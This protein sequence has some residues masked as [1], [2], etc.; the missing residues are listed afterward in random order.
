MN[1]SPLVLRNIKIRT[2][3]RFSK[4]FAYSP[5]MEVHNTMTEHFSN[6]IR[7][8]FSFSQIE[9]TRLPC[10]SVMKKEKHPVLPAK[11]PKEQRQSALS[12]FELPPP[13]AHFPFQ[14]Y[15]GQEG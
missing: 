9:R 7:P 3:G 1:I 12:T 10:T 6:E 8:E 4:T 2:F 11:Y 14:G 5:R 15:R 13:V